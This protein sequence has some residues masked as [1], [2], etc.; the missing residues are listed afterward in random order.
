[1]GPTMEPHV[2]GLLDSMFSSGLSLTLVE[3]LEQITESIPPLLLTIQNRLLKC[4][5]T[6]LSRSHH[7]IPRQST[8]VSRG[9]IATVT[10]QVPELSG[11]ALVQ[12][13]LRTLA[14]FNFKQFC[15]EAVSY[16]SKLI[17]DLGR[18]DDVHPIKFM[19]LIAL[20]ESRNIYHG[21]LK[22]STGSEELDKKFE[23][24]DLEEDE[25]SEIEPDE[26]EF[27]MNADLDDDGE[28]EI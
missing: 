17:N 22:G 23:P 9:H 1:M 2:R 24:I 14:R 19:N 21:Y 28:V 5:S 20:E 8:S 12:L 7:S 4:I 27:Q 11:I 13:A 6:I 3:A 18:I 26:E 10:P 16:F 15:G 25:E